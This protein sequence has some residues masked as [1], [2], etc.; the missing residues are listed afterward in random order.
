MRVEELKEARRRQSRKNQFYV[1]GL[2]KK[3]ENNKKEEMR[4]EL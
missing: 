1:Y 4:I 2:R 3:C